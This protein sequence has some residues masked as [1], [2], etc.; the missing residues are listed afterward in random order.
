MTPAVQ[1]LATSPP[2][3]DGTVEVVLE[4]AQA[5]PE[6]AVQES[7]AERIARQRATFEAMA[8]P[9]KAVVRESGGSVEGEAW[10]NCTIK[11]RVPSHAIE[12]LKE[13]DGIVTIDL[14]RR[15]ERE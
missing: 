12:K 11:A 15:L 7:R 9:V 4:L 5:Q 1:A 8:G 14:P 2:S 6:S 13:V 3:A 10:I